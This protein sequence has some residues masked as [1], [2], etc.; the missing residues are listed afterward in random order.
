MRRPSRPR[1]RRRSSRRST[2]SKACSTCP[3][4]APT[5]A[6][7]QITVTFDVTRDP[8]IAAVDVQ[9]R[10]NQAVGRLPAEVRQLGV[11]VQKVSQ[12]FVSALAVYSERGEDDAALRLELHRRVH[13][14]RAQARARRR[15]RAGVRRTQVLDARLARPDPPGGA[16]SSPPATSSAR[17][18]SRT[19]TWLPAAWATRPRAKARHTRSACA[20]P[21]VCARAAT[22]RTSSSRLARMGPSY[23]LATWASSS[24]A[25]RR[26]RRCF[27]SRAWT[28]SASACWRCPRPTRSTFSAASR[29]RWP[30]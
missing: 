2:A 21:G 17:C 5:A 23:G 28:P 6:S 30:A 19:S 13:Q 24:W 22:S 4:R 3:R 20:P 29:R 12:N 14:G 9:N 10:V 11:T 18:G 25:P 27:A 1:S 7:A 8:D 15:R 26:I 16:A